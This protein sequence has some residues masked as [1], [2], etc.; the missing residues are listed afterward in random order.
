MH[1]HAIRTE[2]FSVGDDLRR[3]FQ[4]Y[5]STLSERSIVCVA[6]KIIALSQGRVVLQAEVNKEGLVRREAERAFPVSPGMT[7]T[8]KEGHWC[9]NAGIDASNAFGHYVL[10]PLRPMDVAWEF[11]SWLREEYSLNEVGVVI[12]DSRVFPARQGVT[13]VALG[14]AGFRGLRDY[15]GQKDLA[16]RELEYTTVNVADSLATSAAFV[17]GEGSERRPLAIIEDVEVEFLQERVR[18]EM[19]INPQNDLFSVLSRL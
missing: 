14:Y 18:E 15:R 19:T 13:A 12:T 8:Y 17:M 3:F 6:S 10:W 5:V 11:W 4:L 16:G 1:V 9:P 7:L 2:I